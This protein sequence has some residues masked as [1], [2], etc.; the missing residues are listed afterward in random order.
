MPSYAQDIAGAWGN[1]GKSVLGGQAAYEAGKTKMAQALA[2][3]D[4]MQAH[5]DAFRS[6]AAKNSA[7]VQDMQRRAQM[8][9]PEYVTKVAGALAGLPDFQASE[10]EQ[11]SRNGNWGMNPGQQLPPDVDGPP[12][13]AMPKSQPDWFKPEQLQRFNQARGAQMAALGLGDKNSENMGKLLSSIIGQGRI[14][15]AISD[16]KFRAQFGP[17]MAASAGKGEFNNLGGN[18]VFNQFTGKQDLNAVGASAAMENRAQAGNASASAALHRA[19]IPEVQSRIDLNKSKIGQAQTVTMPDGTVVST[20]APMPKLTEIQAKSQLFGS[21][22]AESDR[23]IRELEGKYSPAAINAKMGAESVWGVGGALGAAGNMM[24][25]KEGQMAEQAQRDFINAVLRQESGAVIGDSEFANA[26][27]QYFPQPGDS[28]DVLAQKQNNRK[29]AIEGLKVMA[30][31]A[32][33]LV[34]YGGK[35]NQQANQSA[36][37]EAKAAI[38]AGAPRELVIQRLKQMGIDGGGI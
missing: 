33:G 12:A 30:G 38:D 20:G 8:Q 36:L 24:L 31:P 29:M 6:Q 15:Q 22:A 11:F 2:Q 32:S 25:S 23:L 26:K 18:G 37:A 35:P 3:Q 16:P 14:D 4:Q 19:Q 9:S 10:L 13:P 17:A 1:V 5:A 28:K 7:E 34:N 27:K 21:R